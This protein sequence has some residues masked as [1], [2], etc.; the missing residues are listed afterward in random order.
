MS[1]NPIDQFVDRLIE[2]AGLSDTSEEKKQ[3]YHQN[4]LG[5][6]QQK[7]GMELMKILPP[8]SVDEFI[9]LSEKESSPE[10]MQDFFKKNISDFEIKVEDMLKGFEQDFVHILKQFNSFSQ[11]E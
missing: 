11:G 8:D 5:L 7:L 1:P 2:Q 4:I 10:V 3:E 9:A 6:V